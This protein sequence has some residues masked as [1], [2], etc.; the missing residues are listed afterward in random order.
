MYAIS[1]E[2]APGWKYGG[3][4]P[5]SALSGISRYSRS[6]S[7]L[8]SGLVSFFIWWVALRPSKSLPSVQPL[9]VCARIT[10]GCPTCLV[11]EWKAACTL[12]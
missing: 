9:M 1:S 11:A 3:R 5:S 4:S 6:R 2:S 12:R 8:S 10:V 7:S